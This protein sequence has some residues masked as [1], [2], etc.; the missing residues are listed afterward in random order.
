M[1]I[2]IT[3]LTLMKSGGMLC[4][5]GWCTDEACMIRPL[6]GGHHWSKE[7]VAR[8]DVRPGVT[9]RVRP[10]G[11]STREYPHR[12]EDR[13]VDPNAIQVISRGFDGWLAPGGPKASL[14][15]EAAF[16]ENIRWNSEFRSV[17]QGIHIAPGIHCPSL[18]GVNINRNLFEL[19]EEFDSLKA[20]I[21]DGSKSYKL[22]VSSKTLR[23]A[24]ESDGLAGA[25]AALPRRE[26]L[27]VRLGL[28]H[29]Y[30][31][32]PKCYMMLNGAL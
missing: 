15:I 20:V 2:L 4:V 27:H 29:P 32:P 9:I 22:K 11:A 17:Y 6:P 16:N 25:T 8:L 14:S 18:S 10:T 5:A 12:T 23:N 3:D 7:L 31:N 24:W 13:I 28:A 1:D 19:V 21:N 26:L 30:E